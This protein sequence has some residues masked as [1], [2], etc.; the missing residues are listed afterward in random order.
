MLYVN[1][2][3]GCTSFAAAAAVDPAYASALRRAHRAGVEVLCASCDIDEH[4]LHYA[5]RVAVE[6]P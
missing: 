3:P 5:G 4:G 2:R 6:L 1:K